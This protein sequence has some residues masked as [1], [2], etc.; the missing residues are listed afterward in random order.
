VALDNKQGGLILFKTGR[1]S[2]ASKEVVHA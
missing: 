1:I 2:F